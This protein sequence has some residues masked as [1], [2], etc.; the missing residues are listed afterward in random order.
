MCERPFPIKETL[1]EYL[2]E[3]QER[4]EVYEQSKREEDEAEQARKKA[5][6]EHMKF[7]ADS[8]E[9]DDAA[10]TEEVDAAEPKTEVSG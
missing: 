9:G 6:A 10:K 7:D 2:R 5:A 4:Q 8:A 3:L 1:N